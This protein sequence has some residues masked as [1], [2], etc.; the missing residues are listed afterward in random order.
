MG[1]EKRSFL[2]IVILLLFSVS[3]S[4]SYCSVPDVPKGLD[5]AD[6]VFVGE[7][8]EVIEP[9][10]TEEDAPPPGRFFVIRF[11]VERSWKGATSG[12][13]NVCQHRAGM[14][15]LAFLR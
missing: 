13:I 14:D 11:K 5:R 3:I 2:L 9:R 12:Q 6:A 15:S 8:L 7:V 1:I 10:T 4:G